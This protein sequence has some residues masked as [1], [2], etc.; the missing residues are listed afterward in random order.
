VNE[1]NRLQLV[2][3]EL[4]AENPTLKRGSWCEGTPALYGG[5]RKGLLG[6][7]VQSSRDVA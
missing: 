3:A 6:D 5:G 1:L 7:R 4:T 2:V